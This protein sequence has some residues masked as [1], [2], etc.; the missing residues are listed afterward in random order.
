MN[1]NSLKNIIPPKKGEIRNPNGRP[2]GSI[3]SKKLLEKWLSIEIDGKNPFDGSAEKF[4]VAEFLHLKQIERAKN[5][6]LASYKEI[7]DRLE[8]RT[9]AIVETKN[10]TTQTIVWDEVKTYETKPKA[11]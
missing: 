1:E 3:N 6:D 4:T 9:T 7:M 10:E 2:K 8:G 11:D 5:G